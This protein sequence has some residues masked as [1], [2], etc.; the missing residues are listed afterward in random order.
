MAY[1]VLEKRLSTS[2]YSS[3]HFA[4]QSFPQGICFLAASAY[5][6]T[7]TISQETTIFLCDKCDNPACASLCQRLALYS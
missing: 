6:Q 2:I 7:S 3:D 5:Q 1:P 4:W